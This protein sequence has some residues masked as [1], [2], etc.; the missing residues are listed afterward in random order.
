MTKIN[1][2]LA[3]SEAEQE[4]V[5][6]TSTDPVAEA[7]VATPETG[8]FTT[9]NSGASQNIALASA[10]ILAILATIA[11]IICKV[12]KH[13]K[14]GFIASLL[15]IAVTL[16]GVTNLSNQSFADEVDT[17]DNLSIEAP[18]EITLNGESDKSAFITGK[19][20]VIANDGTNYGY[21]LYVLA[22][23]GLDFTSETGKTI[24]SISEA[25]KLEANTYGFTTTPDATAEDAVWYPLGSVAEVVADYTTATAA[26]NTTDIYFGVLTDDTMP[27]GTYELG[28][29]F[30]A[31]IT[32]L[33]INSLTYMQDFKALSEEERAT[34]INS[35]IVRED[36]EGPFYTLKDK[37]DNKEY[38]IG[39]LSNDYLFMLDNL[40]LDPTDA[41]GNA[42]VLTSELSDITPNENYDSFTMPT[43]EWVSAD[44]NYISRA[45]MTIGDDGEYYYNGYATEANPYIGDNPKKNTA[46]GADS[47]LGS[48]CPAGWIIPYYGDIIDNADADIKVETLWNDGDNPGNL[49]ITGAFSN[50]Q[51]YYQTDDYAKIRGK[52]TRHGW[53][54]TSF[55]ATSSTGTT[56]M[57]KLGFM[58]RGYVVRCAAH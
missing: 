47:A 34:V 13:R 27:A 23:N 22:G 50:G 35:M 1:L 49:Y 9:V 54:T 28:V 31:T 52:D 16:I 21:K 12:R 17:S 29:N 24:T 36:N 45:I 51:L 57:V 39:R 44:Q 18:A 26:N 15:V 41:N 4:T 30:Y 43:E 37:R 7:T 5:S 58:G 32:P 10:T 33:T 25:G 20:T 19:A 2:V 42:R 40:K 6:L 3:D 38:R 14:T 55:I 53:Y 11:I 46:E 8:E 56:T 48:I